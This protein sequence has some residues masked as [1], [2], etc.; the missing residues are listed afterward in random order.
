MIYTHDDNA[1]FADENRF[2]Y[3]IY[4]YKG[5]RIERLDTAE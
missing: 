3:I 5:V 4:N 1:M 2:S